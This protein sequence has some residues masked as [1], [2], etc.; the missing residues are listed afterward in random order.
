MKEIT[1]DDLLNRIESEK[2][3]ER[4]NIEVA[5]NISDIIS[6]LIRARTDKNLSQRELAEKCGLHQSAIARM[7]RL[8]TVPRLDTVMR[9]ASC[10][11]MKLSISKASAPIQSPVRPEPIVRNDFPSDGVSAAQ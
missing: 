5:K 4:I 8:Q 3:E 2:P 6:A 11:G 7:E 10:L 9:V 1:F